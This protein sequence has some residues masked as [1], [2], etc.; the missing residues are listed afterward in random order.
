MMV[1][2]SFQETKKAESEST[3]GMS[4]Y[5]YLHQAL[6]PPSIDSPSDGSIQAKLCWVRCCDMVSN[7]SHHRL[8]TDSAEVA[9]V[10]TWCDDCLRNSD[11]VDSLETPAFIAAISRVYEPV[12][13]S[14]IKQECLPESVYVILVFA[15]CVPQSN[16]QR[17]ACLKVLSR[18]R[19]PSLSTELVRYM[20]K[21]GKGSWNKPVERLAWR[22]KNQDDPA[23]QHLC[24]TQLWLLLHLVD[25]LTTDTQKQL[26][27]LLED[28]ED[29]EI[30]KNGFI[31]VK[32]DLETRILDYYKGNRLDTYSARIIECIHRSSGVEC[33]QHTKALMDWEL[34]DVPPSHRGL[35]Q[36]INEYATHPEPDPALISPQPPSLPSFR[37]PSV[38]A[39]PEPA[40]HKPDER[41]NV[42]H[43]SIDMAS[44][45]LVRNEYQARSNI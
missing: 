1:Q 20:A 13:S 11:P 39:A 6:S 22:A 42:N 30:K 18:F 5:T 35:E 29:L 27:K 45:S 4:A 16:E 17:E 34:K 21:I 7:P 36:F 8:D 10:K 14:D 28:E 15:A 19:F 25:D 37:E 3:I 38:E 32:K 44:S 33:D 2:R 9:S 40:L 23:T 31:E 12:V 41:R 24:A 43:A 26:G